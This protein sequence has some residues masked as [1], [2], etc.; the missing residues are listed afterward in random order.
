VAVVIAQQDASVPLMQC[1][2]EPWFGRISR[3]SYMLQADFG[4]SGPLCVHVVSKLL[5]LLELD[6]L[7]NPGCRANRSECVRAFTSVPY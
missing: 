6:F 4:H 2:Q 7:Q 3:I 5:A 1:A